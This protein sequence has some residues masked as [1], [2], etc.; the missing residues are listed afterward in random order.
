MNFEIVQRPER[1]GAL[2]AIG[3][4]GLGVAVMAAAGAPNAYLAVNLAALVIGLALLALLQRNLAT[5][6]GWLMLLAAAGLMATALLGTTN[7]GASRW[8]RIG[9]VTIQPSL[10]LLPLMLMTFARSRDA[11]STLAMLVCAAALALQPDRSMSGALVAGLAALATTVRDRRVILALAAALVGFVV[12]L[13]RPDKLPP[14]A[15]V[16]Q[17]YASAF[18]VSAL[19]GLALL[20]G[21]ALL[22][23]PLLS[24]NRTDSTVFAATWLAILAAAVIGNYPTPLLGYG[25]SGILGYLLCVAVLPGRQ[26]RRDGQAPPASTDQRSD[27]GGNAFAAR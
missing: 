9:V 12:T 20:A 17:V 10:V 14:T 24:L 25:G 18:G 26:R 4:T 19:A 27:I 23:L 16:E 6:H 7:D 2:A 8:V 5:G 1:L 22:L 11:T 21:S 13:A 3:A 15:F